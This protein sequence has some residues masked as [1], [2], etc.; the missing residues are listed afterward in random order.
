MKITPEDVKK[1][2]LLARLEVGEDEVGPLTEHFNTILDYFDKMEELDLSDVD[3]FTIEDAEPLKLRKD[4][5]VRWE[6]RDA[7]L[8]Q[9]PSRQGD[10]I[11]VPRIGG[12][13]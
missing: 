11:K 6:N 12:D 13:A 8:D 3:P 9:S 4:E 5:P 1:V 10:F 7:I 2:G